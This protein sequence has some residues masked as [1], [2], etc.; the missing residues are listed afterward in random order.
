[1]LVGPGY[2]EREAFALLKCPPFCWTQ[3]NLISNIADIRGLANP[4]DVATRKLKIMLGCGVT[5]AV[6]VSTLELI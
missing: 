3:G 5:D 1:M 6:V 4:L 2:L